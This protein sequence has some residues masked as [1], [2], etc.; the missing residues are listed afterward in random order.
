MG[1]RLEQ[2]RAEVLELPTDERAD[3]ATALLASLEADGEDDPADVE[4]AWGAEVRRRL[5]EYDAGRSVGIPAD[6]VFAE[7][8]RLLA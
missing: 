8:R 4:R 1:Q 5:A 2:L 7:A 3:L 6:E